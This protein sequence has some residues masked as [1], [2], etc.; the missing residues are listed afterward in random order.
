[1]IHLE[2][3]VSTEACEFSEARKFH[4]DNFLKSLRHIDTGTAIFHMALLH[5]NSPTPW[6]LPAF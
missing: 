6:S 2:A 5:P 3:A 1:M 4:A